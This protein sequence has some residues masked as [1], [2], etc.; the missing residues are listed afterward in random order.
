MTLWVASSAASP[1]A[2][3]GTGT[4]A[5]SNKVGSST[6]NGGGCKGHG[7]RAKVDRAAKQYATH[8]RPGM[9]LRD[10]CRKYA[11]EM[12]HASHITQSKHM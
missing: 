12:T 8:A 6:V 4:R 9:N 10:I 11:N 2:A 7:H 1:A 5:W 3:A